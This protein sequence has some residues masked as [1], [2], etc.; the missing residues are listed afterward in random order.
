MEKEHDK[1]KRLNFSKLYGPKR[2][3]LQDH[4]KS[5]ATQDGVGDA[6]RSGES[7]AAT[8]AW[9][10]STKHF[11]K[12]DFS[13]TKD[14]NIINSHK[15]KND[16]QSVIKHQETHLTLGFEQP[17]QLGTTA[18]EFK[19]HKNHEV[20][21]RQIADNTVHIPDFCPTLTAQVKPIKESVYTCSFHVDP[22]VP[23]PVPKPYKERKKYTNDLRETHFC[24][25]TWDTK[26][27][28]ETKHSIGFDNMDE[29]QNSRFV[30][31]ARGDSL[32]SAFS[33]SSVYDHSNNNS[34]VDR[35]RHESKVFRDGDWNRTD[36]KSISSSVT[37]K[38]FVD[39]PPYLASL[40]S[41]CGG[42][43]SS[44]LRFTHEFTKPNYHRA[45]HFDLG[46]ASSGSDAS[47]YHK[48]F[49]MKPLT[50]AYDRDKTCREIGHI[51]STLEL[52]PKGTRQ[53]F[54]TTK[55]TKFKDHGTDH[56]LSAMRDRNDEVFAIKQR[57][58]RDSHQ[59]YRNQMSSPL[60][61]SLSQSDEL[62]HITST[63]SRNGGSL[64]TKRM[65]SMSSSDFRRPPLTE[66]N[67]CSIKVPVNNHI[68]G[69]DYD[70]MLSEARDKY[71][72]HQSFSAK[73]VHQECHE[74]RRDNK[75]THFVF[76]SAGTGSP[77][78]SSNSTSAPMIKPNCFSEQ[79][80][81]FR[82]RPPLDPS[83]RAAGKTMLKGKEYSHL[84]QQVAGGD[85][86]DGVSRPKSSF[87]IDFENPWKNNTDC[88]QTRFHEGLYT[89]HPAVATSHLF[90][91]GHGPN[92]GRYD[93]TTF[94]DFTSPIDQ[95]LSQQKTRFFSNYSATTKPLYNIS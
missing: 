29:E 58:G 22:S 19:W 74:R 85:G 62:H 4:C 90:H 49:A 64:P 23:R 3:T 47:L 67:K 15:N 8:S 6:L 50:F 41:S 52:F 81:Q 39:P 72:T 93:S 84:L 51:N 91:T 28:S 7:D 57:N 45:T 83:T 26:N 92:S 89:K 35:N 55:D 53:S 33:A 78:K 32:S 69:A 31:S 79:A 1:I 13:T 80:S 43:G 5:L 10:T 88:R 34:M 30:S 94:C 20:V 42:D 44:E 21:K 12:G 18:G 17:R 60:P 54:I 87:M 65:I 95:M 86:N 77:L 9:I 75:S 16:N 38:D 2:S 66:N 59:I 82:Q 27:T 68:C 61:S 36:R 63:Y 73:Q 14:D 37:R 48:D 76:G 46:N 70:T 24:L 71:K 11:H 56:L 40:S 25:G